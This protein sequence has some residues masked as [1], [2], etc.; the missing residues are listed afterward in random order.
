M[1]LLKE[2][3][4]GLPFGVA[5]VEEL[6]ATGVLHSNTIYRRR[7]IVDALR[8]RFIELGGDPETTAEQVV[9]PLK[10]ILRGH[11]FERVRSGF[12]RYVGSEERESGTEIRDGQPALLEKPRH[13]ITDPP[14]QRKLAAAGTD[15]AIIK[16]LREWNRPAVADRLRYLYDLARDDPEELPIHIR[17]LRHVASFL[18]SNP[19]LIDPEVGTSPNGFAHIEWTLPGFS[20][21]RL[22]NGLLAMEF[23]PSA[24]IRFAAL[25]SPY[26]PGKDRLTVH[27]TMPASETLDAV[28]PFTV[29]IIRE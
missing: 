25:S 17:S 12:Y 14:W 22:G 28:R 18:L 20:A 26:R 1:A 15:S 11:R 7:E 2:K 8:G 19:R 27:G 13:A 10:R 24:M 9:P 3:L 16:V 21:D 6:L 4:I 29:G 5:T 23:L